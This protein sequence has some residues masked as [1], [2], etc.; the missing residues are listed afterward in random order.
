MTVQKLD[1]KPQSTS[2]GRLFFKG[3]DFFNSKKI[4]N[5]LNELMKSSLYL[6]L[7]SKEEKKEQSTQEK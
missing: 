7:K 1:V 6:E 2:S 3:S 4:R 5:M